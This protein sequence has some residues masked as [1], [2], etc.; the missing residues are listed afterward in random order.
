MSSRTAKATPFI[1]NQKKQTNKQKMYFA[2]G[3][4]TY[5]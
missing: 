4:G 3:G 5:L 2:W 1:G